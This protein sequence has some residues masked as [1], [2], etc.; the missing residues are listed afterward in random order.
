MSRI[1]V[2][3]DGVLIA[4][5]GAVVVVPPVVVPNVPPVQPPAVPV[6]S[7]L[8]PTGSVM[9]SLA[10]GHGERFPQGVVRYLIPGIAL[11]QRFSV[12]VSDGSDEID[13]TIRHPDGTEAVSFVAPNLGTRWVYNAQ[14]G[15]YTVDIRS[16]TGGVAWF[17]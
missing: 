12:S 14:A 6:G 3:A 16:A 11:G 9:G 8:V 15:T 17:R 2:Y 7:S 10:P 13:V 1:T 4:D 5:S